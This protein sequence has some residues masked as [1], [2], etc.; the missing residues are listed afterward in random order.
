MSVVMVFTM[1]VTGFAAESNSYNVIQDDAAVR[2]AEAYIEGERY[3]YTFDKTKQTLT[4][5]VFD[6]DGTLLS[7][8]TIYLEELLNQFPPEESDISLCASAH[9]QNTILNYEYEQVE[10][11]IYKLKNQGLYVYRKLPHDREAIEKYVKAVDRL[12]GAEIKVA[13]AAGYAAVRCVFACLKRNM[14]PFEATTI[15]GISSGAVQE[16]YEAIKECQSVWE[17]YVK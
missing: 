3:V 8:D 16:L 1:S 14:T 9:Y 11:R 17:I 7:E 13:G 15:V 4:T 10:S 12:N 2:I 5:Q 6:A